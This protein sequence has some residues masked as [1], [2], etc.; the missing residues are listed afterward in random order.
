MIELPGNIRTRND[1]A[2]PAD[3]LKGKWTLVYLGDADCDETC[4]Q[5]IY[6]MRQ[7]RLAQNENMRRVQRL[8]LVTGTDVP[9]ALATALENYPQMDLALLTAGQTGVIAPLFQVDEVEAGTAERV[10]LIDPLGYLMMYYA[11][12]AEPKGM[13]KDLKKLLKYSRFG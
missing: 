12:E 10:Y 13:L 4:L 9:P 7:V 2:L 1:M 3:Y 11:P 5:N 8:F 6:K